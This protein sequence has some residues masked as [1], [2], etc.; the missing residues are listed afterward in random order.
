[1]HWKYCDFPFK[2]GEFG[3][4]NWRLDFFRGDLPVASTQKC[5]SMFFLWGLTKRVIDLAA[6]KELPP[7]AA[8]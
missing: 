6:T 7:R 3:A 1:M 2:I 4:H 8:L 5:I